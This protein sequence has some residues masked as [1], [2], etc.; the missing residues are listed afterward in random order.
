MQ[1]RISSWSRIHLPGTVSALFDEMC[2]PGQTWRLNMLNLDLGA[3]EEDNLEKDMT[4][5]LRRHLKEQLSN[6]ILYPGYNGNS[7]EVQHG[8]ISYLQLLENFLLYGFMSWTYKDESGSV[9]AIL[10]QLLRD[11]NRIT[12]EK[13]RQLGVSSLN[14][15]KRIAWQV[16]DEN[17][18]LIIKG[19]EPNN[20]NQITD[21]TDEMVKMQQKAPVVQTSG[22]EFRKQ[23][24]LWVLNYLLSDRGTIFNRIAFAKSSLTQMAASYNISYFELLSLINK[25]VALVNEKHGGLKPELVQTL[26]VLAK[27]KADSQPAI[28]DSAE[29]S[30]SAL[31]D[32]ILNPEQIIGTA[33]KSEFNTLLVSL[34]R[35][36]GN[37]LISI[38][39]KANTI[40]V[41]QLTTQISKVT[42]AELF[43]LWGNSSLHPAK[44][45]TAVRELLADSGI[46]ITTEEL[47]SEAF[48]CLQAND[49]VQTDAVLIRHLLE[50]IMKDKTK[51]GI[52]VQNISTS[53]LFGKPKNA[54]LLH[55]YTA[56]ADL[57][58][59]NRKYPEA[60][61]IA[62]QLAT[63][64][65]IAVQMP[66]SSMPQLVRAL[67]IKNTL[68]LNALLW[69][70]AVF[71]IIKQ[72]DK[73]AVKHLPLIFD[74]DT[75]CT[76]LKHAPKEAENIISAIANAAEAA[77]VP[78]LSKLISTHIYVIALQALTGKA[79]FN[80]QIFLQQVIQEIYNL[81]SHAG[82]TQSFYL[83]AEYLKKET[84]VKS[85]RLSAYLPSAPAEKL[86][87]LQQA[88]VLMLQPK[89]QK[90]LAELL[91]YN[92]HD[93][94]FTA[95]RWHDNKLLKYL[96]P[97]HNNILQKLIDTY[98]A[99]L[100][101]QLPLRQ[102]STLKE[103]LTQL[104]WK[105]LLQNI[106]ENNSIQQLTGT[107]NKAVAQLYLHKKNKDNVGA[108]TVTILCLKNKS[109]ISSTD[110][111]AL[112]EKCIITHNAA[113]IYNG[114]KVQ[115]AELM[116]L[117][118][119][120]SPQNITRIL[121]QAQLNDKRLS[122][123]SKMMPFSKFC[124]FL[125]YGV[126]G[127][128]QDAMQTLEQLYSVFTP[129]FG[130]NT[131]KPDRVFWQEA[132]KV[133]QGNT[134]NESNQEKLILSLV[135][136]LSAKGNVEVQKLTIR[137]KDTPISALTATLL[138]RHT[139]SIIKTTTDKDISVKNVLAEGLLLK[140]RRN[141]YLQELT[142]AL[143][144]NGQVPAWLGPVKEKEAAILIGYILK[145]EPVAF[146]LAIRRA[147]LTGKQ[148]TWL[149][150]RINF[151]TIIKAAASLNVHMAGQLKMLETLYYSFAGMVLKGI[152]P[153]QLQYILFRKVIT[154]W[155][156]GNWGILTAGQ[157]WNEIIWE[158]S[159]KFSIPAYTLIN[160]L[161]VN[162]ASIPPALLVSL[163][164]AEKEY[165]PKVKVKPVPA[166]T[167]KKTNPLRLP[168]PDALKEMIPVKNAGMVL[169]N[170][171]I[172]TLLERLQLV[173]N[174]QFISNDAQQAAVH[175]LQYAATGLQNTEE[176]LLP[177][178]KLLCGMPIEDA[179]TVQ[180]NVQETQKELIEG[181][182]KA[183]ISYWPTI[184]Q[185][186][187]AGLR[188]NWF[189]RDGLLTET[190][191]RWELTVEKK[192]Y[193]VLI[194][195]SPFSFSII[196]YPW[197]PKPLH[198]N[199]P[200]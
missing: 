131:S 18:N 198:V 73:K 164:Q 49:T 26:Q 126:S 38:L 152:T 174:K 4:L 103:Q 85:Y 153:A 176:H 58:K 76:L 145:K 29:S 112:L 114:K 132:W 186:S 172:P 93:A 24:W 47:N 195:R 161:T 46:R 121:K 171:Y 82:Q 104:T 100:H 157:I 59:T 117:L 7:I 141:G 105:C 136:L 62:A 122:M 51:A 71:T 200:Y 12:I 139:D 50:R 55:T 61:L 106:I 160:Q 179:M 67:Q 173:N 60:G 182:L 28:T 34:S 43:R 95:A 54:L 9:N 27:E 192:P 118:A 194:N 10:G 31:K 81:C 162:A 147:P 15:R 83:F 168:E 98:T 66:L 16:H 137:L 8:S 113:V 64:Q 23:L 130:N 133:M 99:Q 138:Q 140:A 88:G 37:R 65:N 63:L 135:K 187:V 75:A 165:I 120:W 68:R 119:D 146:L 5:R 150:N 102:L 190:E 175:Y 134:M 148:F 151:S 142:N 45:V 167:I 13:I 79:I 14:V 170:N 96:L 110:A 158:C 108:D 125:K 97:A 177:L 40:P 70:E 101:K 149:H 30:W 2:P 57:L 196:R 92:F 189:V 33:K 41:T 191:E 74:N 48:A 42:F 86:T 53:P 56:L 6:L 181:L 21:F 78:R 109:E 154:A 143:V 111:V 124:A 91:F 185:S 123:I 129:L 163:R 77:Q 193:D 44:A 188:G 11:N 3:I 72:S 183:M 52:L 22:T 169:L 17:I 127:R 87:V 156:S 1:E 20:H 90:E 94:E 116:G 128:M 25:A 35:Q 166:A 155:I 69:P 36:D 84:A 107:L 32:Y 19:L 199:W 89:K 159:T 80:L 184:G 180:I 115:A 197:M 144:I 39:R 178:N